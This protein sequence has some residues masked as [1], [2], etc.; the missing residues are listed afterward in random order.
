MELPFRPALKYVT[1]GFIELR[2]QFSEII[3]NRRGTEDAHALSFSFI[4]LETESLDHDAQTLYQ[5]DTAKDG[6]EQLLVDDDGA[7][8]DDA[9]DGQQTVSPINTCAG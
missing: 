3:V 9:A 5:E 4:I 7:D 6:N 8:T 2:V 1:A